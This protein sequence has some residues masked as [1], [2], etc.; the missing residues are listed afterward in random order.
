MSWAILRPAWAVFGSLEAI[1]A[2]LETSSSRLGSHLGHL[3]RLGGVLEASWRP[4]WPSWIGKGIDQGIFE[5]DPGILGHW[6]TDFPGISG[7][8]RDGP[9][10][11]RSFKRTKNHL[12]SYTPC[13]PVINQQGAADRR[14]LRRVTAAPCLFGN[15]Y[16]A[17]SW[18]KAWPSYRTMC[19]PNRF[20]KPSGTTWRR[21]GKR[22]RVRKKE[23]GQAIGPC[24]PPA[25]VETLRGT[26]GG[27][28]GG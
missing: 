27:G 19:S 2:V 18:A 22:R 23:R 17:E 28:S 24:V 6:P 9:K 13:T 14:R 11:T 20:G 21:T 10:T 16:V 7:G 8:R 25:V 5:I 4:S 26:R 15:A 12:T 3:G 1:L